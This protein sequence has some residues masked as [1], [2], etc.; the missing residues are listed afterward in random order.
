MSNPKLFIVAT[1]IGN[2]KDIALRALETLREADAILCEDTRVTRKLLAHYNISKPLISYHQHSPE[3]T[4]QKIA[5]LLGPG[6]QLALVSDAGTPGIADPGAHLVNYLRR[7]VPEINIVPIPGPSALTAALS[8]AGIMQNQ[9]C[10]LGWPPHKKGRKTFFE[11]LAAIDMPVVF[12]ES[13]HRIT[14]TLDALEQVLGKEREIVLVRELTKIHE[15][16]LLGGAADIK[17]QLITEKQRGEFVLVIPFKP[18]KRRTESI[19]QAQTS[20]S[21]S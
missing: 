14:K 11:H 16:I 7:E 12:Y 3:R 8:V 1:P 17:K 20:N 6:R 4:Y 13:P 19:K 21:N 9:F 15:E 18:R 10:F 5:A 2:L